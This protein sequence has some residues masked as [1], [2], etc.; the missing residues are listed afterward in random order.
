MKKSGID[1]AYKDT[2]DSVCKNN[3]NSMT[4]QV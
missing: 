4:A 1:D 2:D 3:S